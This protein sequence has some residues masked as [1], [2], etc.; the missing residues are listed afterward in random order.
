MH[1]VREEVEKNSGSFARNTAAAAAAAGASEG[2]A[3]QRGGA[4][5]RRAHGNNL[6]YHYKQVVFGQLGS[7]ALNMMTFGMSF[8]DCQVRRMIREGRRVRRQRA[9]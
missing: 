7:I 2:K 3:R 8:D 4:G 9:L 1:A 5:G 6:E